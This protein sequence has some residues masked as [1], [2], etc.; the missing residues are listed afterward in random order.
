MEQ[1]LWTHR[2]PLV[3][4]LDVDYEFG[5][6]VRESRKLF[7]I[8]IHDEEFV[9]RR[10]RWIFDCELAIEVGDVFAMFLRREGGK[11]EDSKLFRWRIILDKY[12]ADFRG[13]Q[14]SS[15]GQ[16]DSKICRRRNINQF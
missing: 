9:R 14:D 11:D 16:S 5:I 7:L 4:P 12:H 10:Q 3:R 2:C 1:L 13:S 8:Q 6:N 15:N